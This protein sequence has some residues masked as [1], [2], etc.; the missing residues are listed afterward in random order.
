[1]TLIVE[2]G[3]SLPTAES[4]VSVSECDTYWSKH[5]SPSEWTSATEAAKE[6]ALRYATLYI[7]D[8]VSWYSCRLTDTQALEWPRDAFTTPSG[9]EI[10]EGT[11]PQKVK[12]AVCEL[13]LQNII[14][15]FNDASGEGIK[16]ERL[17]DAATTYSGNGSKKN[18]TFIKTSLK[19][20]GFTNRA[21][22]NRLYR[23]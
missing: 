8:N 1:M 12:D 14:E 18:F 16:S 9:R 4:Y 3:Q 7:D 21:N 13:A 6:S 2:S 20:Y 5:N 23:N 19:D 17:G 15:A 10:A 22:V 11:I